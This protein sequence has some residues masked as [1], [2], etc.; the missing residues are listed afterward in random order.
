MFEKL[1]LFSVKKSDFGVLKVYEHIFTTEHK[2]GAR[3]FRL[4]IG[5]ASKTTPSIKASKLKKPKNTIYTDQHM[6][7]IWQIETFHDPTKNVSRILKCPQRKSQ[8]SAF[9]KQILS[10]FT[11]FLSDIFN[12]AKKKD[13]KKFESTSMLGGRENFELKKKT[14]TKNRQLDTNVVHLNSC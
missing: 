2:T 13:M 3:V 5:V 4:L 14:N 10:I 7:R 12:S 9:T 6:N 1:I 8:A 11:S